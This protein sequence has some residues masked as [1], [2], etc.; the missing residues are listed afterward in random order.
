MSSGYGPQGFH[1]SA[2]EWK[3][4]NE[5]WGSLQGEYTGKDLDKNDDLTFWSVCHE[6]RSYSFKMY[7][8][9][10]MGLRTDGR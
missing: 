3:R 5:F 4:L 9:A 8:A 7:A 10:R 6:N 1:L 2:R